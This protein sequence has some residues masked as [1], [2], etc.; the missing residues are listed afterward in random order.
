MTGDM[1]YRNATPG[2]G[3]RLRRAAETFVAWKARCAGGHRFE[4]MP[5]Y[6]MAEPGAGRVAGLDNCGAA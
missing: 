5:A 3:S 4:V 6:L 1:R 2:L